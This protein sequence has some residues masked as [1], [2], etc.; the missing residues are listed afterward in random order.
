MSIGK[1]II[2]NVNFSQIKFQ[3]V[4]IFVGRTNRKNEINPHK[5]TP[6]YYITEISLPANIVSYSHG[7]G[8]GWLS[9]ALIVLKSEKS[10]LTTGPLTMMREES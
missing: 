4:S 5:T 8:V 7:F 6:P 1:T 3:Y 9:S 2:Q 10:P